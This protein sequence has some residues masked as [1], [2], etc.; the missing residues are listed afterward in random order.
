L[1]VSPLYQIPTFAR[2]VGA[3]EKNDLVKLSTKGEKRML[4]WLIVYGDSE[5]D[6]LEIAGKVL[7]TIWAEYLA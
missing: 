5:E 4:N 6:A 3:S 7:K 1:F 2:Q